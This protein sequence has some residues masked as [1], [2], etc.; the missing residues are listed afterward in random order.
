MIRSTIPLL[1][2]LLIASIL[3]FAAGCISVQVNLPGDDESYRPITTTDDEPVQELVPQYA[4]E[5]SPGAVQATENESCSGSVEGP[6]PE[7]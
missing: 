1:S 2:L 4:D 6:A 5:F 7:S 3:A